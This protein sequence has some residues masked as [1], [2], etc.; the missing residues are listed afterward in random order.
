V[1]QRQG[2]H[3]PPSTRPNYILQ[4][5]NAEQH[6]GYNIW[7]RTMSIMQEAMLMCI[8][9]T[10]PKFELSAAKLSSQRILMTWLCK[11]ANSVIGKQGELLGY[12]HLIANPKTRATWTHLYGNELG[13]L[14]QGMPG[15]TKGM[16]TIFFIPWHKVPKER[17]KDVTYGLI[18][19]LIRPKKIEVPNRTRL[20][21]GGDRVHY[22]FNAGTPTAALLTVRLL[23]NSVISTM[24]TRLFTMDIK[25]F[26]LC[27][28]MSRYEYMRLKLLDMPEDV[29]EHYKL[30]DIATPDGYVY[31]E[32]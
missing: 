4:D 12:R 7:L 28:P 24:G 13:R 6:H 17:A 10:N 25:N 9:I 18:T 2:K 19:C 30:C 16:D 14:A 8:D 32:I 31:C 5:D 3:R 21:A 15:R 11:M 1:T 27:M 29:I 23:I 26:Y 20:V 22:P